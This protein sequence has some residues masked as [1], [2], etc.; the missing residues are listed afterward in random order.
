M[1]SLVKFFWLLRYCYWIMRYAG[2]S[3]RHAWSYA[4]ADDTSFLEGDTPK[5][6]VLTEL[7]YWEE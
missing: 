5:D 3:F 6:A 7:S 1:Q 4:T 2:V